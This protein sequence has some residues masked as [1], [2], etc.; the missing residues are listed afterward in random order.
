MRV[1]SLVVTASIAS[2]VIVATMF[3]ESLS[4]TSAQQEMGMSDRGGG[5]LYM[6]SGRSM[7]TLAAARATTGLHK[8]APIS[9]RST[10]TP[11]NWWATPL[12]RTVR[13]RRS[14]A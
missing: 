6:P 2:G 11:R 3:A 8:M 14:P 5:H 10:G 4:S 13:L 7:E 1:R 9:T 12:S